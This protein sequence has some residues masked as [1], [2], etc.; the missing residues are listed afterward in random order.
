[1]IFNL[2]SCLFSY[3]SWGTAK[4]QQSREKASVASGSMTLVILPPNP[5]G[6]RPP[7][8]FSKI[9]LFLSTKLAILA[10]HP[11]TSSSTALWFYLDCKHEAPPLARGVHSDQEVAPLFPSQ[12]TGEGD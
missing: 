3:E 11:N 9:E 2:F 1:M 10:P 8:S 7:T 4:V 6:N 12:T 5:N